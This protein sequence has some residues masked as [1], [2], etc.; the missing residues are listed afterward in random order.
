MKRWIGYILGA[1]LGGIYLSFIAVNPYTGN[2]S[3]G[4]LILQLDGNTGDICLMISAEQLLPLFLR[5]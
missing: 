5:S 3:L 4:E 2:I 1:I